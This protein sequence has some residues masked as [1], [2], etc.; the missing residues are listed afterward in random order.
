MTTVFKYNHKKVSEAQP[1]HWSSV[2]GP[3]AAVAATCIRLRWRSEDGVHFRDDVGALLDITLDSPQ[4]FTNAAKRSITR[5]NL[6]AVLLHMPAAA[7]QKD[8]ILKHSAFSVSN[9][10]D[11]GRRSVLVDLVP[12][13]RPL[14]RGSKKVSKNLPQWTAKCK[15]YLTSGINGGQWTQTMK[16]KLPTFSGTTKCQL[17]H[18]SEGTLMHRHNCSVTLP[19]DGWTPLDDQSKA[20]IR[21]L[22]DDRA[23]ALQTRA[24]LTVSLPIAEPQIP[25]VG[26]LWISE[27]PDQDMENLTWVIDGSRRYASHWTLAT[28]GCGVAVLDR[29][30][31][32]VAYA[33]ATPPH[34][35]K[36][37]G[38][39][40]AWALL[41][42]LKES[43]ALPRIITDCLALLHAARSGPAFAA[44]A[45]NTDAR[46]WKQ[47][48][49]CTG[50]CYKELLGAL[51]WMPS[52]TSN[53]DGSS[54]VK[55]DGRSISTAEWR[56]N[57]LADALAK[58]GALV[59]PLREEADKVIKVAGESLRQSASK[60]GVVTH[61]ANAHVIEGSRADGST[62]SIT[63]RDSTSMPPALVKAR[64]E[65]RIRAVNAITG[66]QLAPPAAPRLAAPLVQLTFEQARGL[67]RRSVDAAR[68]LVEDEHLKE[69][70]AGTATRGVVQLESATD[71]LEALRLRVLAK[72]A[73]LDSSSSTCQ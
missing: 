23:R 10:R 45:K 13:L 26:W 46:I 47:I 18:T 6:D 16:A 67:K 2:R 66:N 30:G 35:V 56:A 52:H 71:R 58:K 40:E 54:R 14:Y 1:N 69:V 32:L 72:R 62:F 64:D 12:F 70:V 29:Y 8:D 59:S 22:S 49:D 43:P 37:A 65:G 53:S 4:V 9:E 68:R 15:G 50:G 60:L 25:T 61:A 44:R 57:Q 36:T 34:W 39:A 41:L 42:T 73:H 3:A 11:G 48:A 19:S 20:F 31:K 27:P 21:T 5:L 51:V 38:A 17:C 24:T 55:S 7:P 28:T 33:T 63:K